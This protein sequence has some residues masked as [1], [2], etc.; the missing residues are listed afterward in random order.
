MESP[1]ISMGK[2]LDEMPTG[3]SHFGIAVSAN[4]CHT[5]TTRERMLI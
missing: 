2:K 4:K 5:N 1:R 3:S